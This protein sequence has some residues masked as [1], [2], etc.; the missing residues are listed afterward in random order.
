MPAAVPAGTPAACAGA[1]L[2][3]CSRVLVAA[4][5]LVICGSAE[6]KDQAPVALISIIIDDL[7][8]NLQRGRRTIRLPGPVACAILPHTPFAVALAQEAYENHKEIILH[9][10][11]Q[12]ADAAEQPGPGGLYL[13]MGFTEITAI[14]ESDLRTV[15][16]ATGVS[17]HM[18]SLLT[19]QPEPMR[20]LMQA[21]ARRG[22]L[23]FVDSRTTAAT[24][25]AT[26]ARGF[27]VPNLE[28]N[29]FLDDDKNIDAI[30][31][32][33]ERLIT[34]A[35]ERGG[36]L[37]VG[38]PYPETMAFLE[39]RLPELRGGSVLLVAPSVLL[40]HIGDA[41]SQE[42]ASAQTVR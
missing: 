25:A 4:A 36:A 8:N 21:L 30:A 33:F 5:M 11:M 18:G 19:Q 34:L 15:P 20:W 37:A 39:S 2:H 12:S 40:Q 3:A 27:G 22:D 32:Q 24:V 7:G 16:H 14:L 13:N 26:T 28:R 42:N 31:Q 10:P 41:R 38:H 9:L 1:L 17:N 35:H 6:A 23:F 29:V